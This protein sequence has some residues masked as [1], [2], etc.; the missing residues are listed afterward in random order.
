MMVTLFILQTFITLSNS[1]IENVKAVLNIEHKTY[2]AVQWRSP[3]HATP[4]P[5]PILT[6][7]LPPTHCCMY[8]YSTGK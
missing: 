4:L 6:L 8:P 2:T 1:I 7:P 3:P 5:P